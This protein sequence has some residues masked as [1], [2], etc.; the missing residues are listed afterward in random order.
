MTG[1]H[2]RSP[3]AGGIQ[4]GGSQVRFADARFSADHD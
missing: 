3:Q 1:Y 2:K 4:Q